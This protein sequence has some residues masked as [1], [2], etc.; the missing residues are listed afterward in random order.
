MG[1]FSN[2]NVFSSF[3][4]V[5]LTMGFYAI[6]ERRTLNSKRCLK[7]GILSVFDNIMCRAVESNM[8]RIKPHVQTNESLSCPLTL[9]PWEEFT[10]P[11]CVPHIFYILLLL[12]GRP[13][14]VVSNFK[15]FSSFRAVK[16]TMGFYA[17]LE[18]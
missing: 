16:L 3:R 15:D 13:R 9:S 17:I 11:F 5:K 2:F 14:H 8:T 18:R 12:C 6:L 10:V 4:A 1:V 7:C